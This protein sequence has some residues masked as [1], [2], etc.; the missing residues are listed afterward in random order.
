MA[1]RQRNHLTWLDFL[2]PPEIT[3]QDSKMMVYP[4][5]SQFAFKNTST[6]SIR[7]KSLLHLLHWLCISYRVVVFT[8]C[9]R[10]R[11]L[12]GRRPPFATFELQ[13]MHSIPSHIHI[14]L[15]A[16]YLDS[17]KQALT[18][19]SATMQLGFHLQQPMHF[20]WSISTSQTQLRSQGSLRTELDC[21]GGFRAYLDAFHVAA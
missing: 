10:P 16:S 11:L 18:V 1:R 3:S 21:L 15:S 17:R 7:L 12:E 14:S 20:F 19:A 13:L 5:I 6:V 4:S 9:L 2:C 8:L